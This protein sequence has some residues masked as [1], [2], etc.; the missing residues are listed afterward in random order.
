MKI[1]LDNWGFVP[2]GGAKTSKESLAQES[3]EV[4]SPQ[5]YESIDG[6]RDTLPG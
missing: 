2:V 1:L 4:P 6:D 5:S 3:P